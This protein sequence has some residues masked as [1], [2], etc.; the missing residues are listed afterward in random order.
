MSLKGNQ[1]VLDKDGDGKLSGNDFKMMSKGGNSG[2]TK[3]K[4]G[5]DSPDQF[6]GK[7]V[8]GVKKLAGPG[9]LIKAGIGA[10]QGFRSGKGQGF[11]A[12]LKGAAQGAATVALPGISQALG[13]NNPFADPAQAAAGVAPG[14]MPTDPMMASRMAALEQDM[15]TQQQATSGPMVKKGKAYGYESPGQMGGS[16][17][18][19]T[20]CARR[21]Y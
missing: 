8:G 1:A 18:A 19:K 21:K 9:G 12:R 7:L 5:G 11:M 17:L 3:Y 13:I 15:I 14:A 10:I 16:A 6:L 2:A 4:Q 20:G